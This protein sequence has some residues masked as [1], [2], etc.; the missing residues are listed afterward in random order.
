MI[1]QPAAASRLRHSRPATT[2][3]K[4]RTVTSVH[5]KAGFREVLFD[6]SAALKLLAEESHSRAFAAFYDESAGAPWVSSALLRIEM[7]R[8]VG[9][10][11]PSALPDARGT[12]AGFDYVRHRR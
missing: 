8:A 2:T 5:V 7:I 12:P 3:T 6:T 4:S 1:N 11:M 9:R 10:V